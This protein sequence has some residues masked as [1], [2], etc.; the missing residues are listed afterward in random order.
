MHQMRRFGSVVVSTLAC[1]T[2]SLGSICAG[3]AWH[4]GKALECYLTTYGNS[5]FSLEPYE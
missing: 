5:F 4:I 3:H 2:E 1:Q